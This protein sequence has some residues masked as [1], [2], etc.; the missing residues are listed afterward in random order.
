[1]TQLGVSRRIT[2]DDERARLKGIVEGF[3]GGGWIVR[4]AGERLGEPDLNGDR[5][6]LEQLWAQVKSVAERVNAP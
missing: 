4:T 2:D 5:R 3:G 6:Y 1:V